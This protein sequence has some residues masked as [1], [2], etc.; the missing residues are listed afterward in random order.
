M[1]NIYTEIVRRSEEAER[2]HHQRRGMKL[3][4]WFRDH[5]ECYHPPL[6]SFWHG[7]LLRDSQDQIIRNESERINLDFRMGAGWFER[8]V[9]D[10]WI[11]LPQQR[12]HQYGEK[13]LLPGEET[14]S[15]ME[16]SAHQ[17]ALDLEWR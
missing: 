1:K 16:Y 5:P 10:K 6:P 7:G 2:T 8:V 9:D 4:Q 14:V 12:C 13:W 3:R 17:M 11:G 15:E